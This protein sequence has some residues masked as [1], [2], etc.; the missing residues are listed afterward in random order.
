MTQHNCDFDLSF[1]RPRVNLRA[2]D[3]LPSAII[4]E[5]RRA[6]RAAGWNAARFEA[7]RQEARSGDYAH[8]VATVQ[9]FF[10]VE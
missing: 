9:K 8:L 4:A 3:G 7:F 10:V 2:L 6:S 1:D 5:C